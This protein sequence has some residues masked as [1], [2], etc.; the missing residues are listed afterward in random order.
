MRPDVSRWRDRDSYDFFDMLPVEGLAWEC[1]RRHEPYQGQYRAL[2]TANTHTLPFPQEVQ[3]RWG[4]RFPGPPRPV[5]P[6]AERFLVPGR[7]SGGPDPHATS[8][9]S[10]GWPIYATYGYRRQAR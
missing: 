8:R 6:G 4:L 3:R 10:R 7:S 9:Y 2:V 5:R 1:L